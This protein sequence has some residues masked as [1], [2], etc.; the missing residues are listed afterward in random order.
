MVT[1]INNTKQ[2]LPF[3]KRECLYLALFPYSITNQGPLN[4]HTIVSNPIS[5]LG[6]DDTAMNQRVLS[7]YQIHDD[8]AYS[9]KVSTLK[10][11]CANAIHPESEHQWLYEATPSELL[12]IDSKLTQYFYQ[13]T[14]PA[15]SSID[16]VPGVYASTYLPTSIPRNEEH[17]AMRII[18]LIDLCLFGSVEGKITL[19]KT[20]KQNTQMAKGNI[21]GTLQLKDGVQKELLSEFTSWINNYKIKF[22]QEK[23]ELQNFTTL[24]PETDKYTLDK[25]LAECMVVA[26][27]NQALYDLFE[28]KVKNA[29]SQ[30]KYKIKNA[31]KIARNYN[32]SKKTIEMLNEL[33][34]HRGRSKTEVIESLIKDAN[35][36]YLASTKKPARN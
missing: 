8:K 33:A 30:K 11:Y 1:N 24:Y 7:H 21:S 6:I 28:M 29:W 22:F 18:L 34:T 10:L 32:F 17:L 36:E 19:L 4:P 27:Q 3:T 14:Q 16:N 9:D 2:S 25:V 12:F 15:P 5:Y 13:F 35:Q 31:E 23:R 20:L 26:I